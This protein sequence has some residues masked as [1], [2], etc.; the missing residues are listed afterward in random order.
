MEWTLAECIHNP[1]VMS[2][3][4]AELDTVV[5]SSRNVVDADIPR[6]KYLQA[7]VK[8]TFRLHIT[9]IMFP[10]V[11]KTACK[12]FGYDVP[13]G[14]TAFICIGAIAKDPSI[15]ESPLEYKPERFLEGSPHASADVMG[16][17]FELLSF[18]TGRRGCPGKEL[19]ITMV[20]I[21]SAHLLHSFDWS[22]PN[23]MA[24]SDLDMS[25]APGRLHRLAQPL[26]AIPAPREQMTV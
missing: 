24:P 26:M 1:E 4:K 10:H 17:H 3:V 7:M 15:W 11:N 16:A 18:G 9:P 6:L 13:A 22:L 20:Q 12:V 19:A 23:G 25:E 14:T 2:K 8:E 5:G 21:L